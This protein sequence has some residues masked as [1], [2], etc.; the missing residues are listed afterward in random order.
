[1]VLYVSAFTEFFEKKEN[2]DKFKGTDESLSI[3][4][5]DLDDTTAI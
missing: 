1:M 3:S 5:V 4:S 2:T